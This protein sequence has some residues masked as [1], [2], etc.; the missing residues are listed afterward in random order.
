MLIGWSRLNLPNQLPLANL[1]YRAVRGYIQQDS[2]RPDRFDTIAV[3]PRFTMP[4]LPDILSILHRSLQHAYVVTFTHLPGASI[5]LSSTAQIGFRGPQFLD[6]IRC[7]AEHLMEL[8]EPTAN[9]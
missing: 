4:M 2:M 3:L 6:F 5:E 1:R 9:L 8:H 7:R